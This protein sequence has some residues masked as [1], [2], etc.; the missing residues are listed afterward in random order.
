MD[1]I[2]GPGG[3]ISQLNRDRARGQASIQRQPASSNPYQGGLQTDFGNTAIRGQ[4]FGVLDFD[5]SGSNDQDVRQAQ[6]YQNMISN[7][8]EGSDYNADNANLQMYRSRIG[9][10]NSLAERIA[11]GNMELQGDKDE[12]TRSTNQ[13]L[14]EGTRNTRQNYNQRGLLY[15]GMREGGE[16]AV[17][18][19]VAGQYASG[20][21]GAERDVGN[22]VQGAKAAYGAVDLAS[23]QEQLKMANSAFDTAHANNIAR[24]QAMQQLGQ[25]VGYGAGVVAGGYNQQPAQSPT[26]GWNPQGLSQPALGSQYSQ[27]QPSWFYGQEPRP[28]AQPSLTGGY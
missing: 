25:G 26:A 13:A 17:R 15:S 5:S 24:L 8:N 12:I 2:S 20:M 11:N 19:A 28:Y 10:K 18:G 3:L 23:Q 7:P 4:R 21:A 16:Q 6:K 9:L 1:D 14:D 22:E 27:Q